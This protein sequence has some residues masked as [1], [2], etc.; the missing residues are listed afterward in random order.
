MRFHRDFHHP[1]TAVQNPVGRPAFGTGNR[2]TLSHSNG[3]EGEV[4]KR[5]GHKGHAFAQTDHWFL[6]ASSGA[7]SELVAILM[8]KFRHIFNRFGPDLGQ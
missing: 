7:L 1:D 8:P 4:G 3:I 6:T 2:Q 5:T